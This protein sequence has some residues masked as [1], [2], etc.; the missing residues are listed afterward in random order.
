M[1]RVALV[2]VLL[3]LAATAPARAQQRLCVQQASADT[4]LRQVVSARRAY[5]FNADP[6]YIRTLK[7]TY[8]SDEGPIPVTAAE[9]HYLR[10]RDRLDPGAAGRRYLDSLGDVFAGYTLTDAWPHPAYL[11]MHFTRDPRGHLAKLQRVARF[12]RRLRADRVAHTTRA[13]RRLQDRIDRD[14]RALARAGF[15]LEGTNVDD[16]SN[17]VEVELVTARDDAAAYFRKR[18]GPVKTVVIAREPTRLECNTAGSFTIAPDDMSLTIG[19]G[20]GGGAKTERIEVTEFPDRVEIGIVERVPV[21][22]RTLE[23]IGAEGAAPLSQPLAGRSVIDASNGKRILQHGPSPGDPPCPV[24]SEPSELERV[25]EERTEYGMRADAPYVQSL[26]A[27]DREFTETE[28]RWVK[29]V[30]RLDEENRIHEYTTHYRKEWG[31]TALVADYPAKPYL[32]VR[33]TKRFAFHTRELKRLARRPGEIR[34]V[35]AVHAVD[36]FYATADRISQDAIAGDRFLDGYGRSGFLV[37]AAN[38]HDQTADV[39]VQVIT[40]RTDA[41]AYFARYGDYVKVEVIGDRFE[42]A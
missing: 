4:A 30:Q 11:L 27:D 6:A 24:R 31:G 28:R 13:L 18:Y 21:G 41:A 10:A 42:C 29:S 17:R 34:T 16:D 32:L 5:G 26:L 12:P 40:T 7:Q 8:Q 2:A 1:R 39:E 36:E 37:L 15:M 19:W 23:L 25:T 9:A 22:A 35:R 38:G 14:D 3:C 33:L 20:T